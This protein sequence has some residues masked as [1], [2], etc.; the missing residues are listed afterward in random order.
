[1]RSPGPY[2]IR[3]HRASVYAA[4][5]RIAFLPLLLCVAILTVPMASGWAAEPITFAFESHGAFFSNETHQPVAIDPQVFVRVSGAPAGVG[6]QGITHIAGLVPVRLSAPSETS[7]Y[8]ADGTA[9]N[10]TLDRW[11]GAR[12]T[13]EV[14]PTGTH[15]DRVTVSLCHP[16]CVP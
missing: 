10:I 14:E 16:S 3:G 2:V 6:P 5:V 4:G 7:L 12:G 11:L 1:M 8:A 15:T 13:V 9:L